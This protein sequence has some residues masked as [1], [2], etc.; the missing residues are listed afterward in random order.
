MGCA[1]ARAPAPVPGATASAPQAAPDS[2]P[3]P[4]ELA[5]TEVS[6][7][8]LTELLDALGYEAAFVLR[9]PRGRDVLLHPDRCRTAY[10]PAST[11]KIPNSLIGLETGVVSGPDHLFEWD[12]VERPI[13]AWNRDHTLRTAFQ[14][15]AVWYYQRVARE[16]GPKR[17]QH[18]M[19]K[20]GYGNRDIG[21]AVD[22][23]W[24]DGGMRISPLEQVEFVQ[25]LY[26]EK[27]PVS[28]ENQRIVKN[29]M[30]SVD[31]PEL[32]LYA[33]TGRTGMVGGRDHGW[34][35]GY[36]ESDSGPYF[37]ATLLTSDAPG[38]D[39]GDERKQVT[40]RLLQRSGALRAP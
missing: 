9:P 20:L 1:S 12:G 24:L 28:R 34:Y 4:K 27:L 10:L 25:H 36:L 33:K 6:I 37:F 23:F 35:V 11:F 3:P 16:V 7:T 5:E 2:P 21:P 14:D 8:E 15:S 22:R 32:P 17:M 30:R 31:Y 18:W 13:A 26:E 39:F 38:K 29:I 19:D 40:L